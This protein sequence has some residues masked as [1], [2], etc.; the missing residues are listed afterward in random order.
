MKVLIGC[1][2]SQE[3]CKAFRTRGHEAYSCDLKPCSGSH[4]E[5]HLIGD[6]RT[7]LKGGRWDL[8]VVHPPCTDICSSGARYFPEKLRDG[9]QGRAITFF[10]EMAGAPVEKICIEN[11]VGIMSNTLPETGSIHPAVPVRARR[12]EE[13]LPVAQGIASPCDQPC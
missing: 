9:R 6:I 12:I 13:Y 3:I 11:P 1:E 7:Y 8:F 4:P 5:W 10:M 2:E